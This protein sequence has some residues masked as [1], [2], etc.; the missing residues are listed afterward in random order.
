MTVKPRSKRAR[1]STT[2]RKRA[3]TIEDFR[4]VALSLPEAVESQHMGHPDFRVRG[5]IFPTISYPNEGLGMVQLTPEQQ[6]EFAQAEP[7]A[8]M[9]VKGG[10]GLR[11]ATSVSIDQAP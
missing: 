9:P 6:R 11:G 2:S 5:K 4:Q 1:K 3:L 10:W 8:F 7:K